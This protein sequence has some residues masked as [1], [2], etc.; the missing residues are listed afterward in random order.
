MPKRL[1]LWIPAIL[2]VLFIHMI[3]GTLKTQII[4]HENILFLVIYLVISSV[5]IIL[6]SVFM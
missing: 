3:C 2:M 6:E 4:K 5:S 1:M